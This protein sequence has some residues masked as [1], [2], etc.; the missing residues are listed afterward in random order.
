MEDWPEK[1]IV[2][3]GRHSAITDE[4]TGSIITFE[5]KDTETPTTGE[6]TGATTMATTKFPM[7]T[8][9]N[10]LRAPAVVCSLPAGI[11]ES[12]I[13]L[14]QNRYSD[15]CQIFFENSNDALFV[16]SYNVDGIW[17]IG[18][19]NRTFAKALGAK[20]G[21]LKERYTALPAEFAY[22]LTRALRQCSSGSS[23]ARSSGS[24]PARFD[25]RLRID[26]GIQ[27]WEFVLER[28]HEFDGLHHQVLGCGRDVTDRRQAMRDL[29]RTRRQL[30]NVQDDER[31]R[32]AR[33][34]H[35]STAQH[36]VA[37]GLGIKHLEILAK[38]EGVLNGT[39]TRRLIA[40]M[41]A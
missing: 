28:P 34:L 39:A 23:P 15:C 30:L 13:G 1:F 4:L 38:R 6:S 8:R 31:R 11:R 21:G 18:E 25:Q 14:A 7:V 3:H 27:D 16:V 37:L 19:F 22:R 36:L 2:S 24:S 10:E 9:R 20:R 17:R 33:D 26:G 35:D 40:D 29:K 12:A 5:V 41:R 32:I